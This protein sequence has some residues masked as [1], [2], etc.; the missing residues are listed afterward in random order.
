MT[1]GDHYALKAMDVLAKSLKR[2]QVSDKA[3][4]YYLRDF[5]AEVFRLASVMIEVRREVWEQ[6]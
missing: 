2:S 3:D 4:Y 5:A 1:L 6:Q